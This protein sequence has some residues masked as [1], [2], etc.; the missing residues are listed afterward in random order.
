VRWSGKGF[1][2]PHANAL[3]AH[4]C[5]DL[6]AG[7]GV[8]ALARCDEAWPQLEKAL[9]LRVQT[10]RA[11]LSSIRARSM[12]SAIA[13]DGDVSRLR[14]VEKIARQLDRE[15][16]PYCAA[17]AIMLRAGIAHHTGD[18][19]RAIA[20]LQA[21]E[22]AYRGV[23]LVLNERAVRRARGVL[24]GGD[25]GAA[26]IKAAD[27]PLAEQGVR[28]PDRVGEVFAPGFTRRAGRG[29]LAQPRDRGSSS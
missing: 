16:A 12:L 18:S 21:A 8:R 4:V 20:L 2:L 23:D 9:L 27:A 24:V 25:E 22:D 26:L 6:Y 13:Q 10:M 3:N 1:Q 17:E 15:G 29:L 28:R 11:I 14:R 7:D 19:A 5:C